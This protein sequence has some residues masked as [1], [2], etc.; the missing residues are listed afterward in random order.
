MAE[1]SGYNPDILIWVDEIGSDRR[2]SNGMRPVCHHLSVGGRHVSAI[3]VMTTR[4]IEYIFT[5]DC[6]NGDVF[7]RFVNAY[8]LSSFLLM[9]TIPDL[10]Q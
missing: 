1:V 6:V 5:T 10:F 7:V 9:V 4:G 3:P 2:H 8:S